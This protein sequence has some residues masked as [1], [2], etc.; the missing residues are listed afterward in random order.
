MKRERYS[1]KYCYYYT[2][3]K[4]NPNNLIGKLT[5]EIETIKTEEIVLEFENVIRT[6]L[7]MHLFDSEFFFQTKFNSVQNC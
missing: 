5:Y 1:I 6:N 2:I 3:L 4:W 7:M